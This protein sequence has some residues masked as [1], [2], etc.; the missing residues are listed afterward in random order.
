MKKQEEEFRDI[1]GYEGYQV[2][3]LGRVKS[4]PREIKFGDRFRLS[5][6]IILKPY[7]NIYGYYT[8]R[9]NKYNKGKTFT[10]HQLVAIAFLNHIPDGFKV[11]VDHI[12]NN[13]LDNRLENLQLITS[14]L[15]SSKDKKDVTSKHTG[16]HWSKRR[17]KWKASIIYNKKS[18]HLGTFN[19]E[20]EASNY[21]QNALKSIE[22]NEEIITT[23]RIKS[24][25]YKGVNFHKERNKWKAQI[26]IKTKNIHLGSFNT[27]LE[28]H[29]AY[30][31]KLK[32]IQK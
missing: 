15:N 20:E 1:P 9:L 29:N 30:Q 14:R 26:Y 5:K 25:I 12:N 10:V 7:I 27:E 24:S 8:V 6:E 11:V 4:L 16:V 31:N 3:N 32:E 23:K 21:Y 2:S 19:S 22:N 18:I 17:N 13:K 28:A